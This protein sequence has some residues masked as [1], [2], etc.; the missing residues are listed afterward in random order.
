[1][2]A[3]SN[4]TEENTISIHNVGKE[5]GKMAITATELQRLVGQFKLAN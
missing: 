5:A 3:I 2:E 1:M 4:L